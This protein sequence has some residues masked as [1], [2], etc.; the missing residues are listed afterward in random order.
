MLSAKPQLLVRTRILKLSQRV[1]GYSGRR[2]WVL[3]RCVT[4]GRVVFL[5]HVRRVACI[6]TQYL[7]SSGVRYYFQ[8]Q[9]AL[10]CVA[11]GEREEGSRCNPRPL[12]LCFPVIFK[13]KW[14]GATFDPVSLLSL[15]FLHTNF[16]A[17]AFL[18]QLG[19]EKMR[20]CLCLPSQP[21]W[22][23]LFTLFEYKQE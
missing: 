17:V 12:S 15:Y 21:V 22:L 8:R 13:W 1:C 23:W 10:P 6:L 4:M 2:G 9:I 3:H 7:R 19:N 5:C 16:C 20:C 14:A 18:T 11:G